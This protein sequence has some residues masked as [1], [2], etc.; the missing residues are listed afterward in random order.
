MFFNIL[1]GH[2]KLKIYIETNKFQKYTASSFHP[3]KTSLSL[4]VSKPVGRSKLRHLDQG[5]F[6]QDFT[7]GSTRE[8]IV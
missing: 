7:E 2:L 4:G 3:K 1:Y 5:A 8:P 6:L